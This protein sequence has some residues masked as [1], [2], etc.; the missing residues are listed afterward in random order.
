M[1][2]NIIIEKVQDYCHS[3]HTQDREEVFKL[4]NNKAQCSLISPGG[5]YD[6]FE[7][8]YQ[9]F[10]IEGI[11]AAY[12]RIDL[13]ADSI[14][15]NMVSDTC[16]VV[17]FAYHT[18][19]DLRETGEFFGISGLETQVYLKVDSEWKLTHVHYSGKKIEN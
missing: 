19:C 4:W 6:C 1:D 5:R 13:I 9:N 7:D 12:S 17:I 16:A 14:D 2:K 15:V 18:D 8:I 10:L 3:V 11:R